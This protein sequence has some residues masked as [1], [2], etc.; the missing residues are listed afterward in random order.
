MSSISIAEREEGPEGIL[1]DI[2]C[3][4]LILPRPL[5]HSGSGKKALIAA[6]SPSRPE[7]RVETGRGISRI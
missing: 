7:S 1:T 3:R 4:E 5:W 6:I 2:R